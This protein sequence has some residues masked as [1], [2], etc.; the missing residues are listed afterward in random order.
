MTAKETI[1]QGGT[2][3]LSSAL[4]TFAVLDAL[5]EFDQPVRLP[6]LTRRLGGS[7]ATTYQ[8]LITLV[9]AGWVEQ[10]ADGSFQLSMRPVRTAS[11][12]Y[13]QAG[14]GKR[15]FPAMQLLSSEL[16]ESVS[17]VILDHDILYIIEEVLTKDLLRVNFRVG[18]TMQIEST[19]SGRVFAAF[20]SDAHRRDLRKAGVRLP[21][22][23][24]LKRVRREFYATSH[25]AQRSEI[26]AV[27][28]PIF[29]ANEKCI[30]VLSV[31]G[32]YDRVDVEKS[33]LALM[34]TVSRFMNDIG[35]WKPWGDQYG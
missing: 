30:A 10:T 32:P 24:T 4:R 19:A 12:A 33:R 23:E 1:E 20:M 7:R 31:A 27:G 6:D 11:A 26:L 34:K 18:T 35:G 13:R 3:V 16:K 8:K 25:R 28:V 5:A 14:L 9:A 2:R 15:L 21:D 29:D 22:E 17:L